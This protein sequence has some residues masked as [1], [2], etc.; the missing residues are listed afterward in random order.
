MSNMTFKPKLLSRKRIKNSFQH[1]FEIQLFLIVASTGYGKTTSLQRFL[2]T[3][4]GINQIW[5][6]IGQT[7]INYSWTWTKLC[8]SIYTLYPELSKK[9]SNLG[10]PKNNIEIEYVIDNLIKYIDK[11]LVFVI[12]DFQ[13]IEY[14]YV[15]DF[16]KNIAYANIS[17]L[18]IIII[19]RLY[20]D[21]NYEELILK[22]YCYLLDQN[23]L[24]FTFN[25]ID[26][27]FKLNGFQ[28]TSYEIESIFKYTEGWTA[29]IYLSMICYQRNGKFISLS[30][31]HSLIKTAIYNKFDDNVKKLLSMLSPLDSFT[32]EQAIFITKTKEIGKIIKQLAINN[33]FVK[34]NT[35]TKLYNIHMMLKLVAYND[36]KKFGIDIDLVLRLNGKWFFNKGEYI[37]A[38]EFFYKACD[39][40][41]ILNILNNNLEYSLINSV[42]T[43]M[44]SIF[45]TVDKSE[46]LKYPLV[47][48]LFIQYYIINEDRNTGI[49]M[50][51]DAKLFYETSYCKDDKNLILGEIV[52][53]ERIAHFQ[54][55]TLMNEYLNKAYDLFDGHTSK[56]YSCNY[57]LDFI[58]TYNFVLFH[59]KE[60]QLS[61]AICN[62][63]TNFWKLN[64]LT[65][66]LSSGYEI[67][68]RAL[69]NFE[70]G[71][72]KP[73]EILAYK[74]Y[75][76][77]ISQSKSLLAYGSI[78]ILIKIS[79]LNGKVNELNEY[80]DELKNMV[81]DNKVVHNGIDIILGYIYSTIGRT[82]FIPKCL[83]CC[84][85][86]LFTHIPDMNITQHIHIKILIIKKDFEKVKYVCSEL[87]KI[88]E[89]NNSIL[90]IIT[91]LIFNSIAQYHLDGI[92]QAKI[93]L[94]KA[95]K[96]A[97]SDN[98]I[99]I[100]A[101][102]AQELLNILKE[103]DDDYSKK[104]LLM[105][106]R[107][108]EG[109]LKLNKAYCSL[110]LTNKEKSI[111]NLVSQ[112][113]KNLEIATNLS[114]APVTVEKA[115]SSIYKKLNVRN[116]I[117]AVAAIK[118][119]EL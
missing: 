55:I 48:I 90:G 49:K 87:I 61:E 89:Q 39:Y 6:N 51:Y 23:S 82:E 69:Y 117:E 50:L 15:Y 20:P 101:E 77:A 10:L 93:S 97:K 43:I 65:N 46:K 42:S 45:E 67:L 116:R 32:L 5:F 115:L 100:F 84:D 11:P 106:K 105:C 63:E 95:L 12:D 109:A 28:L 44:L 2:K 114:I 31:C 33:C 103:F 113:Y 81:N 52:L 111:I 21:F 108:Y 16:I 47:Y 36:F 41:S 18:H 38:I 91:T 3:K 92:N 26:D 57:M 107:F 30:N 78:F 56:I 86:D 14:N 8:E 70:I 110:N 83:Y 98:I 66:N 85:D 29:A 64:Q 74:S 60:G 88:Y 59:V 24:A 71:E 118:D 53:T 72:I 76:K 75:F 73:A 35:S 79:I 112:G 102:N 22:G 7:E 96:L 34:Y 104:V 119:V 68:I 80:I 54:D 4:K 1:I 13:G 99:M 9:L 40:D 17:N 19:S 94:S 62:I 27:L 25:E 37:T 58:S